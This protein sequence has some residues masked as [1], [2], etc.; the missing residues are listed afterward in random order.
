[1]KKRTLTFRL[2]ALFLCFSLLFSGIN[3]IAI[4]AEDDP[5]DLGEYT[6]AAQNGRSVIFNLVDVDNQIAE[7][8]NINAVAAES[9]VPG[10]DPHI[11]VSFTVTS[12][13][14]TS[15]T[16]HFNFSVTPGTYRTKLDKNGLYTILDL[17]CTMRVPH[18]LRQL[19]VGD[20]NLPDWVKA[21][22]S[23]LDNYPGGR[24][25]AYNYNSQG[26]IGYAVFQLPRNPDGADRANYTFQLQINIGNFRMNTKTSSN[27]VA[28]KTYQF[29]YNKCAFLLNMS[30]C[31]VNEDSGYSRGN[32]YLT[33]IAT[34][35]QVFQKNFD[36]VAQVFSPP[37][38]F[39]IY[40]P[41]Y[42]FSCWQSTTNSSKTYKADGVTSY[43]LEDFSDHANSTINVV[44]V[45]DDNPGQGWAGTN[46]KYTILQELQ[47][48]WN[49]LN[50]SISYNLQGGSVSGNPSTYTIETNTFTLKNP[51]RTG[52]T[53]TGWT[54]SSSGKTISVPKGTTGNLS[55]TANWTP[56][57]YNITYDLDG[58]SV[59]G[60]PSTYTIE[61]NT[62][63]LKNPT[64]T[65]Y[66]L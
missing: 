40:K 6:T 16:S 62:F 45:N 33:H 19:G 50:Y 26:C 28:K 57:N 59:S 15:S 51:T 2:I 37:D 27:T 31:L 52:Y 14:R 12:S 11:P 38:S 17:T 63:T 65:G 43:A 55:F 18:H 53:F 13:A 24:F 30:N 10:T 29:R 7:S 61:T 49:L 41:G 36:G 39:G 58:G 25:G 20:D 34:G 48:V 60:N 32:G 5:S 35:T 44:N 4:H 64:R 47:P 46:P 42:A 1:M 8:Y 21:D 23:Y 66:T 54:G 22:S 56:I 9:G 3:P